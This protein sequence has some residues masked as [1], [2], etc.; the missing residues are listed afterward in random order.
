MQGFRIEVDTRELNALDSKKI[1]GAIAR[2]LR[3]AGS[4]AL[5]DMRSEASK[6]IRERKRLKASV[7]SRALVLRRSEGTNID[8]MQWGLDVRGTR[9]PLS[10]YPHRQTKKGVSVQVNKGKRT[11]ITSAFVAK[12]RS[13]HEGI[14]VRR[15]KHRLPI[16]ERMGSRPVDA[17]LHRG[18]AEAVGE[19]G[20]RSLA[21]TFERLLP[22]ELEK[23]KAGGGGG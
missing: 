13:G 2:A 15:G 7:V 11:L 10:A 23:L 18:E 6:R 12:M 20:Q 21:A 17:L 16:D 5:R 14:F 19:R 4:T 9:V 22:M 8:R 3:K 1:N